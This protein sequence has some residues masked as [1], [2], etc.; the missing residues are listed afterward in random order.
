M[1]NVFIIAEAGVNHNGD[2][3]LAKRLIIEAKNAGA[4]AV[5]FQVFK[6][7][8]L[9][10]FNASKADYQKKNTDNEE[11]QYQML[12]KLE[13]SFD[14][15]IELYKFCN[16][17]KIIFLSSAFDFES[18]DFLIRLNLPILKIPS[19]EINNI[20]YL[21]KVGMQNK[22][23]ILSTGMASLGEIEKAIEILVANGT[24]YQN[25]TLLHCTTEYPAPYQ[26]INLRVIKTLQNCFQLDIGYSDHTIGIEIPIAA[27]ALGAIVIEKHFSI[28]KNLLGPDHKASLNPEEFREMVKC[29]RNVELSLGSFI[30]KPSISEIKNI[31][32]ARKSIVASRHINTGELFTEDNITLKR[33]GNGLSPVYWDLVIG[34][35]ANRDYEKDENIEL[36]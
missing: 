23:I 13:L 4:D 24:D 34:K 21:K 33:P 2:I 10:T 22:K 28:D 26:E 35:I 3:N 31:K 14:Q 36:F 27:V 20:P 11:N 18:I 25:I 15:F 29:I 32:I 17:N 5:K 6:T 12:K 9:V 30:K 19:G 7:E 8:N 1:K 16:E